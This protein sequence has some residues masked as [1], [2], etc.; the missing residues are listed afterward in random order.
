MYNNIPSIISA[1]QF[2]IQEISSMHL[3]YNELTLHP[4]S[5]SRNS[6]NHNPLKRLI[7]INQSLVEFWGQVFRK[8][9]MMW[10]YSLGFSI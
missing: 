10:L 8:L 1:F 5:R 7:D 6:R 3:G 4:L 2:A 9:R